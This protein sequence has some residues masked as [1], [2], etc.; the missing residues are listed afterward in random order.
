M[1][2]AKV[3]DGEYFWLGTYTLAVGDRVF[4]NVTAESG[5]QLDVGF[6]KPGQAKPNPCYYMVSCPRTDGKL[7]VKS[8][9][10]TWKAPVKPGEYT[11]FI[12]TEGSSLANV[13]GHIT[14]IKAVED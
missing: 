9:A 12:H 13:K 5:K 10:M 2:I 4:Y 14:I 6:A 1:D 7:E 8:G 3:K 11:L